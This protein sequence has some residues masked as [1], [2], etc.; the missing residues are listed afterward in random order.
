MSDVAICIFILALLQ[1]GTIGYLAAERY[2]HYKRT[3]P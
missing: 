1:G 2:Y 3:K